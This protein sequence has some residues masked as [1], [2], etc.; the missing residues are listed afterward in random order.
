MFNYVHDLVILKNPGG[1]VDTGAMMGN[2]QAAAQA[3]LRL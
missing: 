1:F 2:A 3:W